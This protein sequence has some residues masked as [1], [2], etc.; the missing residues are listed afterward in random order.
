MLLCVLVFFMPYPTVLYTVFFS[1]SVFLGEYFPEKYFYKPTIIRLAFYMT[2]INHLYQ[3]KNTVNKIPREQLIYFLGGRQKLISLQGSISSLE[4]GN[5]KL[6]G[7]DRSL[8]GG[9]SS[10]EGRD[11][12]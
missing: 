1:F 8:V 9:N 4:G 11:R 10:L 7:R 12:S 6:E 3:E 5:S 2:P